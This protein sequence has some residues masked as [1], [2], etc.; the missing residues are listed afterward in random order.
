MRNY[1]NEYKRKKKKYTE[2]RGNIEKELGD[3]LKEKL[4]EEKR[5]IARWITENA[6]K[7]INRE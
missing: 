1:E 5:T 2:I 6:R 4:K 3:K 7:Y